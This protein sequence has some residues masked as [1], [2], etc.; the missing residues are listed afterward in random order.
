[1]ALALRPATAGDRDFLLEVYGSTRAD[2]LAMV[3]WPDASKDAFVEMQFDAQDEYYRR[4]YPDAS[5]DVVVVD[6]DPVGRLYVDR[7]PEEIR[8]VD[9][10]LV[11]ER[12]GSGIGTRLL[13]HVM[14]E[15]VAAGKKVSIHVE[16]FNPARHLYDRLG[17]TLAVD[18]GVHLLLEWDPI[19]RD[20]SGDDG[21]VAH[22]LGVGAERDEEQRELAEIGM[23]HREDLL[24]EVPAVAGVE[25][26][27]ER[28]ALD[29]SLPLVGRSV[30]RLLACGQHQ[31]QGLV[32][33]GYRAEDLPDQGLE[34]RAREVLEHQIAAYWGGR[35]GRDD[36]THSP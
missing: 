36:G 19:R 22:P 17:F 30:P 7:W 29:G 25:E 3:D 23:Q 11:A 20:G 28:H 9:I 13:R 5:F 18:K 12:R 34:R 21:L 10:A 35:P 14:D 26:Q 16:V 24:G 4:Y 31:L 1:V 2:E 32:V 6:G 15:A 33:A 8:I 27:R